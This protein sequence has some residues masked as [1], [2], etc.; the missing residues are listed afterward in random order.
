MNSRERLRVPLRGGRGSASTRRRKSFFLER[1]PGQT[2]TRCQRAAGRVMNTPLG[3]W[4]D[5]RE[6]LFEAAYLIY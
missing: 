4:A 1:Q 5:N 3:P 2:A 6:F